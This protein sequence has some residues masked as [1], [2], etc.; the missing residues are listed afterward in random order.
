MKSSLVRCIMCALLEKYTNTKNA[1]ENSIRYFFCAVDIRCCYFCWSWS[2]QAIDISWCIYVYI[3]SFSFSFFDSI[4]NTYSPSLIVSNSRMIIPM[5]EYSSDLWFWF[6]PSCFRAFPFKINEMR[7][8]LQYQHIWA[9]K[10]D[11]C[12]RA[13]LNQYEIIMCIPEAD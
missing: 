3:N 8:V 4:S 1:M 13:Q 2:L 10:R 6:E 11:H 7:N 12:K 9:K 5:F